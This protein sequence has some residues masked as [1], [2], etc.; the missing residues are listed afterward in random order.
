MNDVLKAV[1][2]SILRHI[3]GII[4]AFLI[5]R[6]LLSPEVANDNNLLVLAG[7]FA[8]GL[9]ALALIVYNKLKTHNLVQAAMEA[10]AGTSIRTVKATADQKPLL[11]G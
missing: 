8:T 5:S 3:L 9:I 4:A 2:I 7:G 6:G 10:P 11:G 1:L